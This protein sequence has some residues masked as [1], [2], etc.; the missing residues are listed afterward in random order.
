MA[1]DAPREWSR[2]GT[3]LA[4]TECADDLDARAHN[5][6][7]C[8]LSI[9]DVR[10]TH[11]ASLAPSLR[12]ASHDV[13]VINVLQSSRNSKILKPQKCCDNVMI[14]AK[15]AWVSHAVAKNDG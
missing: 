15:V 1:R 12:A 7:I 14:V 8:P 11:R 3:C 4:T 2:V 9:Q 10:P 13:D 6:C 5:H